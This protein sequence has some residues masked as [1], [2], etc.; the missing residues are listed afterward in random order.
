MHVT[1]GT[2]FFVPDDRNRTAWQT[3]QNVQRCK[4]SATAQA[5]TT[6]TQASASSVHL[7]RQ[8]FDDADAALFQKVRNRAKRKSTCLPP[9]QAH[10]RRAVGLLPS[11]ANRDQRLV[12]GM[13][14]IQPEKQLGGFGASRLAVGSSRM[15]SDARLAR[16]SAISSFCFILPTGCAAVDSVARADPAKAHHRSPLHNCERDSAQPAHRLDHFG[17]GVPRLGAVC[18]T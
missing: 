11:D 10:D 18:G 9:T 12:F 3:G 13:L 14:R 17:N 4:Q 7:G 6:Q 15:H 2:G 5:D 8:D 16:A 1:V